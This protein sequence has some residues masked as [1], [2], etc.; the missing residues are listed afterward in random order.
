MKGESI[1]NIYQN[2]EK[3]A[4]LKPKERKLM[5]SIKKLRELPDKWEL[6]QYMMKI[7]HK[8]IIMRKYGKYH[9][10]DNSPTK[11]TQYSHEN[12]PEYMKNMKR[13]Y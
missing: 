9:F 7:K 2:I 10:V 13:V 6:C 5:R 3:Q 11:N 1:V 12:L 8:K 4:Q